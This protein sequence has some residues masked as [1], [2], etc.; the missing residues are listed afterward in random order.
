MPT[1][2]V[3]N[4]GDLPPNN[5]KE[6]KPPEPEEKPK[7]N[8]KKKAS[9]KKKKIDNKSEL[10]KH[11]VC[12]EVT[13]RCEEAMTKEQYRRF[14]S[15]CRG[16]DLIEGTEFDKEMRFLYQFIQFEINEKYIQ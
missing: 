14:S 7:K 16:M 10:E 11:P 8:T 9:S 1:I 12:E 4:G 2:K 5:K 13:K 15:Y 3:V 6:E